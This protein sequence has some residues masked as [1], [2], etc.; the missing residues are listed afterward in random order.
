MLVARAE[1]S[2]VCVRLGGVD[3]GVVCVSPGDMDS[4]VVCHQ[5]VWM[6]VW[7]VCD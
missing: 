3:D 2:V 4:S 6:M 1:D 5:V 7:F